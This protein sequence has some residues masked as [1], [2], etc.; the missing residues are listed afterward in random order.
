MLLLFTCSIIITVAISGWT[1]DQGGMGHQGFHLTNLC[2]DLG[3]RLR[4]EGMFPRGRMSLGDLEHKECLDSAHFKNV[5]LMLISSSLEMLFSLSFASK[6]QCEP[7]LILYF[8]YLYQCI[9][10]G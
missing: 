2:R 5:E 6:F 1:L 8:G 3:D 10:S 4:N 9:S 7:E